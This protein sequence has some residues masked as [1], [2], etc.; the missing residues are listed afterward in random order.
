MCRPAESVQSWIHIVSQE[1]LTKLVLAI[2]ANWVW[3]GLVVVV[4]VVIVVV[5]FLLC[6][7]VVF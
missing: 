5:V 3:F 1:I 7:I 2:A 6:F 4:V